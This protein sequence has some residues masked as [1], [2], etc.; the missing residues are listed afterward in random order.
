M[1]VALICLLVLINAITAEDDIS[2]IND[3]LIEKHFKVLFYACRDWLL[4]NEDANGDGQVSL[5]EIKK[6]AEKQSGG[7]MPAETLELLKKNFEHT[8]INSDGFLSL[9]GIP[10]FSLSSRNP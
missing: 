3:S 4:Q 8:D 10:H 5:A 6:A 2:E 7:R 1:K 9:E